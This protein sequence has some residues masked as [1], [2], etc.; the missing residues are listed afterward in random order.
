MNVMSTLLAIPRHELTPIQDSSI[1][2]LF[3]QVPTISNKTLAH[4]CLVALYSELPVIYAIHVGGYGSS[5]QRCYCN[6]TTCSPILG[7]FGYFH[8][9]T[10][11]LARDHHLRCAPRL[12]A[13]DWPSSRYI[14]LRTMNKVQPHTLQRG[15]MNTSGSYNGSLALETLATDLGLTATA[16]KTALEDAHDLLQLYRNPNLALHMALARLGYKIDGQV[17]YAK[18]ST[19]RGL[20][21]GILG[22]ATGM[23]NP[24]SHVFVLTSPSC[25]SDTS[26]CSGAD[27]P[28]PVSNTGNPLVWS[29]RPAGA[30]YSYRF[31]LAAVRSVYPANHVPATINLIALQL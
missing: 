2:R 28:K 31:V 4:H 15:A 25:S 16:L 29:W 18:L 7:R 26:T 27:A 22:G 17:L 14:Y 6:E 19:F 12:N 11:L 13:R 9:I 21:S 23:T 8:F 20:F 3:S 5:R 24:S 30:V 1:N 10:Y